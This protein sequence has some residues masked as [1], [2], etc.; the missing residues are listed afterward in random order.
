MD[1]HKTPRPRS[2]APDDLEKLPG[3]ADLQMDSKTMKAFAHP[4]RMAMYS[5]LSDKGS[6]TATQLAKHLDEST[7]QTSYHLRQLE[8]HGLVE[9]DPDRGTGRERWWKPAGFS[10]RAELLKGDPSQ[11]PVAQALWQHQ[12]QERFQTL[13]RWMTNVTEE[14]QHWIESSVDSNSTSTMSAEE[15]RAMRD[16]LMEVIE[17]HTDASEARVK[18]SGPGDDDRRARVY[19]SV[20][21]L[22]SP[23]DSREDAEGD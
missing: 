15:M 8:K 7:G 11:M 4:L 14:P 23:V 2:S 20:L 16:E 9:E 1:E 17:R 6:A 3:E 18:A 5:Y 10:L 19:L 22:P 13:R 21:P 12:M